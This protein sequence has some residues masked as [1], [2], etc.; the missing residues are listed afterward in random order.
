[1]LPVRSFAMAASACA[2]ALAVACATDELSP[3]SG[4]RKVLEGEESPD[5]IGDEDGSEEPPY[6]LYDAKRLPTFKLTLE[7]EAEAQLAADPRTYVPATLELVEG[8]TTESLTVGLRL[9][10]KGSFRMLPAKASFRIKVDKYVDDQ[11]LRGLEDLTLNNMIQDRSL[12]AERLAYTAFREM[13][14]A[15]PRANHAR[16][17]LNGE[18]YGLYANI[19]TPNRDFLARWF[20]D[21]SRNLYE[22]NGRDF[23]HSKAV[24][25][26]ELETNE[27][28]DDDRALLQALHEATTAW[29]L[30]RA[31]ELV[32]WPKF[33][34]YSAL[35]AAVNQVDGYSFAQTFPNN[36]RIYDSETGAVFIPW[37]LDWALSHVAT[38]DGGYY[39]D[40]FWVRPSHGVLMRMC[41]AD[42]ACTAEY[43]DAV[44]TVAERWDGL[45]LEAL[46]DEWSE[47]TDEAFRE[48]D[49]R[50]G[51]IEEAL[52]FREGRREIVHN[53][54]QTLFDALDRHA[55]E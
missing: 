20:E 18:Y 24:K 2:L 52:G 55:A 41:R 48:H 21:P 4:I 17:Y 40:P 28:A 42:E 54:A 19:E 31:R 51:S 25:S 3:G 36:Y 43:A 1:M 8:D 23:N 7:P 35:E 47:Q 10:G 30:D 50:E 46:L 38:Q 26:F 22:Q 15:A 14:V 32:D 27:K 12:M 53:R 44:R 34:I 9:K 6:D 45:N 37:G 33:M 16:V 11:R 49:K 13:G 5:F 39:V 29:D